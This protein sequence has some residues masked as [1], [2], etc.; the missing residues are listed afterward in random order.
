MLQERVA[1]LVEKLKTSPDDVYAQYDMLISIIYMRK[2]GIQ[3]PKK[4]GATETKLIGNKILDDA[5][6]IVMTNAIVSTLCI[7]L[8]I[9]VVGWQIYHKR[10]F[11]VHTFTDVVARMIYCYTICVVI[12]RD[13]KPV[14]FSEAII[15]WKLCSPK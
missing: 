8:C 3:I 12:R 6:K 14:E 1:G 10:S 13:F 9:Y 5:L 7:L 15:E 11:C 4:K 2:K